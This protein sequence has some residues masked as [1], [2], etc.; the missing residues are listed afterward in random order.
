MSGSHEPEFDAIVVGSGITGGWAA[1][2]LCE[3]G[4]KVLVLERGREIRHDRDYPTLFQPPW[5]VPWRGLPDRALWARDYPI[6]SLCYAFD[7][8]TRHFFNNDRANPYHFEPDK[9]FHWVRAGV[10]GGKSL[11]WN[12][13]VY[14]FSDLDFEA[15]ARDGNGTDWPLRYKDIEPWYA[16]VERFI[17]VSGEALGL[18]HLPD[19]IFQPPMELNTL[20]KVLQRRLRAHYRDRHVTIGRV[21]I[22]TE[23]TN[24]RGACT[25]CYKCERGCTFKAAFSSI[26]STL[27]AARATGRLTLRCDSVVEGIDLDRVT[28]RASAVRVIDARTRER[29]RYRA[30]LVFLCGSTIGS[31]QIL[32]NSANAEY[33]DGLG[34]ASGVLGRYLFEHLYGN[35]AYGIVPGYLDKYPYGYRPN[36]MY[37]PR[38][39][40]LGGQERDIGFVRGYGFQGEAMRPGWQVMHKLTPGFGK[41]YKAALAGPGPWVMHLGGFGEM[42]PHADNRMSL[43]PTL[44]DA[45]GIPL[46]RF[47]VRFRDNELAMRADIQREAAAMLTLAG[48]VGVTTYGGA[49]PGKSIHEMGTA[50]M[51]K[52]PR[53]SFLNGWNQSH[54]IANLFVT[55][56]ASMPSGACVNPSLTFMALTARAADHAVTLLRTGVL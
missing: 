46:A 32:L 8:T 22:Q 3:K 16:H 17:G 4:L 5:Q 34:N 15:N 51:G 42:L 40:N 47:D 31:T 9:P 38:F 56:G 20:E 41:D 28:R 37:I 18:P 24:D 54:E 14:R 19:S 6:Q 10:L 52:D 27:P 13:Q 36:G 30:R 45:Y 12:R 55:D 26:V 29:R 33:P 1:K 39:R 21:A 23:A 48:A 53:T 7:E 49:D 35:G 25:Y 44:R 43:H 11:L 50:R 2:E